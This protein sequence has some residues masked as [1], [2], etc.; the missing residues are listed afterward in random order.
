[1]QGS[2]LLLLQNYEL[3]RAFRG[4]YSPLFVTSRYRKPV[5]YSV[6]HRVRVHW[7]AAHQIHNLLPDV[8]R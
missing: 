6:E 5:S 4:S 2:Q 7:S 3:E 1:M 8:N